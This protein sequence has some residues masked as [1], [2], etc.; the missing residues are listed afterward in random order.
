MKDMTYDRACEI[1]GF[2]TPKSLEANAKLAA[3]RLSHQTAQC[4]LRFAVACQVLISAA[5]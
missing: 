1:L 5:K 3:S 2:T 4:P